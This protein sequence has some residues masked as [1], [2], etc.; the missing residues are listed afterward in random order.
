MGR[1]LL[2]RSARA[3]LSVRRRGVYDSRCDNDFMPR[4][5]RWYTSTKG[6]KI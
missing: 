4:T 2:L 1:V 3:D 5:G 6:Q